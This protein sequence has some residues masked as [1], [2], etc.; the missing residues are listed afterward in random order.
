MAFNGLVSDPPGWLTSVRAAVTA[1]PPEWFTTHAPPPNP[2]RRSAVLVLFADRDLGAV[3]TGRRDASNG[4]PRT[5][6]D[7]V[8]TQRSAQMRTQPGEVSFPGGHL[9]P[10]E[11]PVAAA[12]R[13]AE[14]EVGADP[15]TVDVVADLP[16]LYL[17]PRG[18]A[19]TPVLAWWRRPHPIDVVDHREVARVVRAD[20]DHLLDPVNRFTVTMPGGYRGPGFAVDGLFVWGFTAHLLSQV[21]DLGGVSRPWDAAAERPLPD[22]LA[23]PYLRAMAQGRWPR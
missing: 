4:V 6:L 12:I 9:D 11:G 14:E 2:R 15:R 7:V 10:G 20:L 1:R 3:P 17:T 22:D 8:L 5:G 23:A 19:V 21:A 18:T 13:E 16:P